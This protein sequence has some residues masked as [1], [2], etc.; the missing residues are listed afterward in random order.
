MFRNLF[1]NTSKKSIKLNLKHT[2]QYANITTFVK[3]IKMSENL[4]RYSQSDKSEKMVMLQTPSELPVDVLLNSLTSTPGIYM[5]IFLCVN[6]WMH[7]VNVCINVCIHI[8]IY[9]YVCTYI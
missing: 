7:I 6:R 1:L 8:Y 9:V 2:Q 4:V 3:K 5:Y